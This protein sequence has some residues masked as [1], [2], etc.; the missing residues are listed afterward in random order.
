MWK[1]IA[2]YFISDTTELL[3]GW[4]ILAILVLASPSKKVL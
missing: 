4:E 1:L 2:L 3:S